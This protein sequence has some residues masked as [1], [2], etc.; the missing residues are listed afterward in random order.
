MGALPLTSV[1]QGFD[2]RDLV[3]LIDT[4]YLWVLWSEAS[5]K[6]FT[7]GKRVLTPS[8]REQEKPLQVE[9]LQCTRPAFCHTLQLSVDRDK[10]SLKS[11]LSLC[12]Y[13][14]NRVSCYI[15]VWELWGGIRDVSS[16]ET[17]L[18]EASSRC[19]GRKCKKQGLMIYDHLT[20]SNQAKDFLWHPDLHRVA[21]H[22]LKK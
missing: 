5:A 22:F 10:K 4:H 3:L 20:F 7:A 13:C 14:G 1:D 12:F 9:K 15:R 16:T 19:L 18:R 11:Q 2:T 17:Q 8:P 21:M 6:W